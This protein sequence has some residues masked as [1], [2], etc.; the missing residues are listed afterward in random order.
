MVETGI[1][2]ARR[3]A[4]LRELGANLVA[5]GLAESEDPLPQLWSEIQRC[6]RDGVFG[7]GGAARIAT[8]IAYKRLGRRLR[9]SQG[10]R[11]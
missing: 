1:E 10:A 3:Y 8:L 9:A 11:P 7:D 5:G 2:L 4:G 6:T